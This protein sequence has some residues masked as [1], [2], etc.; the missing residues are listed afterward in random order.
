MKPKADIVAAVSAAQLE[1][2]RGLMRDYQATLPAKCRFADAE[3]QSLP[4]PYAPPHGALL[5]ATVAGAPAGCVGLRP[6]PSPGACEMKR[7]YVTPQLRGSGL[8]RE[9]VMAAV[10]RARELGYTRMRLDTIPESMTAAI[11]LYRQF[12]FV[13]LTSPEPAMTSGLL[14]ME[15]DLSICPL[16]TPGP[17]TTSV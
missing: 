7:L 4:G 8:G 13:V 2:V 16:R 3:W 1:S 10:L 5:L 17:P 6:F 12:G 14:Y 15:L 9:L 11:G